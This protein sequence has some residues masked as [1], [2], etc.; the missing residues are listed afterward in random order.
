VDDRDVLSHINELTNLE[1]ELRGVEAARALTAAEQADLTRAETQL[2]Q[3]WDLLRQ[4]RARREFGRDPD[5][6]QVR[7]VTTVE[8]YRQ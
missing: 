4:R 8:R 1:H 5:D 3:C 7:D 6:A 2:D